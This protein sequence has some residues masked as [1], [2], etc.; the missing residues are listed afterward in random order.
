M[1]AEVRARR[2]GGPLE[3]PSRGDQVAA[4]FR[5][6]EASLAAP[7][8]GL[9]AHGRA[10]SSGQGAPGLAP[11]PLAGGGAGGA[12]RTPSPL[13]DDRRGGATR[14]AQQPPGAPRETS[15]ADPPA[16]VP[17][18]TASHRPPAQ[19]HG[20]SAP[21]PGFQN[22][23]GVSLVPGDI[24]ALPMR[25]TQHRRARE[26]R[27]ACPAE[28]CD[29]L[30][31]QTPPHPLASLR[32]HVVIVSVPLEFVRKPKLA[33]AQ[34]PPDRSA[35]ARRKDLQSG[36]GRP[37][38]HGPIN[39]LSCALATLKRTARPCG[40]PGRAEP[41]HECPTSRADSP[42]SSPDDSLA[43]DAAR[44]SCSTQATVRRFFTPAGAV[45]SGN[46]V[47]QSLTSG[48]HL[49]PP[50]PRCRRYFTQRLTPCRESV[51]D[52]SEAPSRPCA[53]RHDYGL[54]TLRFIAAVTPMA[55]VELP[56]WPWFGRALRIAPVQWMRPVHG[57]SSA[58]RP[59]MVMQICP[60]L[61]A[62]GFFSPP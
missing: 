45:A 38:W 58:H 30:P 15:P 24:H 56:I 11:V 9:P 21:S 41:P 42:A 53:A 25:R 14:A 62:A 59:P 61:I 12:R 16:P 1:G 49:I 3:D 7:R 48:V 13:S 39:A 44:A 2:G 20:A 55:R 52:S 31:A 19:S 51:D 33:S 6:S 27:R 32:R 28:Q 8:R 23:R 60:Q 35:R 43:K 40:D 46:A 26:R 10:L 34:R 17:E 22:F 37:V 36:E 54:M 57:W 50:P 5:D 18:T 47:R 4:G 29:A